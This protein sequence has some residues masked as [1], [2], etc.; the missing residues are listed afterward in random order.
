M[1]TMNGLVQIGLMLLAGIAAVVYLFFKKLPNLRPEAK[2]KAKIETKVEKENLI[3]ESTSEKQQKHEPAD[4]EEDNRDWSWMWKDGDKHVHWLRDSN[5][6]PQVV[7]RSRIIAYKYNSKWYSNA[8]KVR[9]QTCGEELVHQLHLFRKESPRRPLILI[10]HSLGGNVI[11]QALLFA[12]DED[13]YKYLTE[14]TAGL[15]FLGTPF[16][17]TKWQPF[18]NG[19]AHLFGLADSHDGITKELGFDEPLLADRL[20]RFC[21][22][23]NKLNIAVSCFS[24]TLPTDYGRRHV[25][26]GV[27]STDMPSTWIT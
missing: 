13:S 6:L 10:G 2:A 17:G 3:D 12:N 9:L 21:Q 22:L 19:L 20:H 26:K 15:V 1:V 4:S 14:A 18:L 23:R 5:M 11:L 7:E 27:A 24:E 25:V 16:R 8:P